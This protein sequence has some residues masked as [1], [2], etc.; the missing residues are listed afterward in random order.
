[1][2]KSTIIPF[3]LVIFGIAFLTKCKKDLSSEESVLKKAKIT[4]EVVTDVDGNIYHTVRIGNQVWM[5]ENMKA[6][7]YNDGTSILYRPDPFTTTESTGYY[8]WYQNNIDYKDPYGALYNGAIGLSWN[9]LPPAGW[10]IPDIAEWDALINFLGVYETA[11]NKIQETGTNHWIIPNPEATNESGFTAL[12]SGYFLKSYIGFQ[13]LGIATGW[14]QSSWSATGG[15]YFITLQNGKLGT[16]IAQPNTFIS[17]RCIKDAIPQLSTTNITN[18]TTSTAATG[19]NITINGGSTIITAGV[20]WHTSPNPTVKNS[21]TVDPTAK[22]WPT[23]PNEPI[24]GLGPFYSTITNLKPGKTYYV[25]AYA[26]NNTGTAY[27]QEISFKTENIPL[28]ID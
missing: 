15:P 9:K 13:D 3:L 1:M 6:T 25:R 7:K 11:G 21:K 17:V 2:K 14:W 28:K 5:V 8:C 18:I 20:C 10:H 26:T 12:P 23:V 19:G 16:D 22:D 27:G 24:T 4:P